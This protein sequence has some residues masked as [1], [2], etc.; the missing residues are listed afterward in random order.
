MKINIKSTNIELT[1]S[2][3]EWVYKKLGEINLFLGDFG[4]ESTGEAGQ[5]EKTEVWVEIGKIT[6]HHRK[7]EVF[8]AEVQIYLP[9][10]KIRVE[11]TSQDLRT[12]INIAKDELQRSI[13]KYKGKRIDRARNWARKLKEA[14]RFDQWLIKPSIQK[15]FKKKNKK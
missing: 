15:I 13:K 14:I 6:R 7:G 8:R 1:E 3:K 12:A 9:K 5:R 4:P 2:L 11:A 10:K